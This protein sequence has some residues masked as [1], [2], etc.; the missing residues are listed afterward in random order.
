VNSLIEWYRPE[1]LALAD[2][3]DAVERQVFDGLL[4]GLRP[5]AQ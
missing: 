4:G 3:V 1:R 5:R 2:L